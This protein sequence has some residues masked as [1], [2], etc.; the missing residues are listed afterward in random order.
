MIIIIEI[1]AAHNK[2]LIIAL[3]WRYLIL[4]KKLLNI[5]YPKIGNINNPFDRI[6]VLKENINAGS[7]TNL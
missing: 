6:K 1:I 3:Y 5:G 4:T 2:Q 7:N